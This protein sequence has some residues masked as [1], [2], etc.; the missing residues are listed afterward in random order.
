MA[1]LSILLV[2]L[3]VFVSYAQEV[4][5]PVDLRQHNLTEYNSSLLSPVFSLDRNNPQSVALWTRWQWQAIDGDPTTIFLNYT[6][7]INAVSAFG[8][9]FFQHNTGTFL[10]TGG[11][12]NY[13]YSFDLGST[14]QLAIGANI[15]GFQRELADD[16][17]QPDPDIGLPQLQVSNDFIVQFAPGIRLNAGRFS[18]GIAS[19]NLFDY[20]FSSN[21][22]ETQSSDK[23]FL[24]L[25]GYD[26][27]LVFGNLQNSFLRPMIYVKT[28]P[29]E[30]TQYGLTTLL[31]TSKFWAQAGYNSFYGMSGGIGGRFFKRLSVGVLIEFGLDSDLDNTDPSFEV[32]T[33]F[34][35]GS[36]ENRKEDEIARQEQE[37]KIAEEKMKAKLAKAEANKLEEA[38]KIEKAEKAK[39]SIAAL[40]NIEAI[41]AAERRIAQKRLDSIGKVKKEVAMEALAE[42][43]RLDS[44][45][46]V[47]ASETARKL[48]EQKRM[49]S[50]D[51]VKLAKAEATKKQVEQK[52]VDKPLPNEKYQEIASE[53]GLEPG[54]YLIANVFGTKRY[55][56]NFMSTL[57]EKG[58]RPKS[59]FRSANKYNYVYLERYNTIQEARKTRDNNFNG[60]YPDKTWI[61]RVV[62]N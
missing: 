7:G 38:A 9:G 46:K 18:V 27:P 5:L 29:D 14:V 53:D 60:R 47:K 23:I 33:A 2:S 54:Y 10:N 16:R 36:Y 42:Q 15:F 44:I 56:D 62:G 17:F 31:S 40:R 41:A 24:G 45:N 34:N 43:K 61:F 26:F 21:E 8:A 55:F 13:A 20:N 52:E 6:G 35:F 22:S 59:F 50:I 1:K 49:D 48:T 30:D 58:L 51:N 12:I 57:K 28:I 11:V 19:E 32:V 39:D 4:S 25:M 3:S 37:E